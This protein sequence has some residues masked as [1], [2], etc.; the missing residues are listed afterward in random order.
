MIFCITVSAIIP[1][2]VLLG[3]YMMYAHSPGKINGVIGY[4]TDRSMKN[5]ETWNY[6]Q[7]YCGKLWLKTGLVMITVS[8]AVLLVSK[9]SEI[10]MIV[11]VSVQ[12]AAVVLSIFPVE[13][14]LERVFD[15]EG[16]RR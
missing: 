12:T 4:R 5:S 15:E 6:A 9:A 7:K 1:V 14:E 11:L 8:A 16:R 2:C 13:R 3:G 10:V